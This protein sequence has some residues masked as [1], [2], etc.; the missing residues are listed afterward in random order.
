MT[1]FNWIQLSL[2]FDI[3]VWSGFVR[4]GLGFGGA[5]LS[6]PFLLLIDNQPLVYLPIISI[7][8]LVFSTLTVY[9]NNKQLLWKTIGLLGPKN[10]SASNSPETHTNDIN[11]HN[12]TVD[13][14]V[15]K[16]ALIIMLIPKIIGVMGI[17]LF[18]PEIMSALIFSF[19]SFYAV[20]YIFNKPI[21]C[22]YKWLDNIFLI[23]GAYISGTSLMGGPLIM[24]VLMPRLAK[25]KLRDSIFVLWFILV[26]IKVT[27]LVIAGVDLQLKH[28]IWLLPAAAIGHLIGLKFHN[29]LINANSVKF[30][31][32]LGFVLIITSI[33][34]LSKDLAGFLAA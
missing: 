14:G 30:Y 31:R 28:Q 6:M 33:M 24:A 17:I 32:I 27:A 12:G 4:T 29:Y 8:L 15:L 22:K 19:V 2:I 23:L 5:M 16:S 13:W 18:P 25:E 21:Q 11:P 9:Q 1:D 26:T 34:G 10:N 3:F 20:T 7:H